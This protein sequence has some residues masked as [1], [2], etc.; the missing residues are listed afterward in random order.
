MIFSIALVTLYIQNREIEKSNV[1][2]FFK[3]K[4]KSCYNLVATK[5]PGYFTLM[6]GV[7]VTVYINYFNNGWKKGNMTGMPYC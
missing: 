3:K 6:T 7:R 1:V 4:K 2:V 5:L